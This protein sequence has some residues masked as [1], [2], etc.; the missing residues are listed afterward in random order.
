MPD[1]FLLQLG[2]WGCCK[3]IFEVLEAQSTKDVVDMPK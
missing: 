2:D 3:E 1:I